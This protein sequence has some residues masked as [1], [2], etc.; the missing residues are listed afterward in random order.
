MY[1][2]L[3]HCL[4]A[5]VLCGKGVQER[6]RRIAG[7]GRRSD[8]RAPPPSQLTVTLDGLSTATLSA[9]SRIVSA[10]RVQAKTTTEK[11]PV[12]APAMEPSSI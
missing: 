9:Q 5:V 2:M 10:G 1:Y 4:L 3:V 8:R 7:R 6:R 12:C 11:D